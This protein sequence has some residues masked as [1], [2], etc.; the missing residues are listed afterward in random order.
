VDE[1]EIQ[2]A[3]L[4]RAFAVSVDDADVAMTT[5]EAA[6]TLPKT[7]SAAA[8]DGGCRGWMVVAGSFVVSMLIYG[9]AFTYGIIV[10]SL[11]D[12]FDCGRSLVGGIGSLMIGLTWIAGAFVT[13]SR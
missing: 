10:P 12:H 3:K 9:V 6:V 11:V 7:P 1:N 8:T 13:S 5:E 2:N 4:M